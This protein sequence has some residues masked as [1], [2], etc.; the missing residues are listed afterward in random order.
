VDEEAVLT[1]AALGVAEGKVAAPLAEALKDAEPARRA[2]AA[3][4]LGRYGT[5]EQR[6]A[7]RGLLSDGSPLVRFRAAQGLLAV[8]D[9]EALLPLAA[10][11]ADSSLPLALRADELLAA[12]ALSHAPRVIPGEDAATRTACR[13][14][15]ERWAR[16]W[17]P[18]DLARGTVDLPPANPALQAAAVCRRFVLALGRG[19]LDAGRELAEVPCLTQ[20]TIAEGRPDLGKFLPLFTQVLHSQSAPLAQS[21]ARFLGDAPRVVLPVERTF[22]GRF[23]KGEVRPVE[24]LWNAP[25]RGAGPTGVVLLVRQS[26]G[27]FRIV[28]ISLRQ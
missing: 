21:A 4:V 23:R 3:L 6:T 13:A 17:G 24:L 22:L 19:D 7:V 28:G 20:A 1:L 8:R 2:A 9:R 14:A 27:A 25:E 15:W 10:L 16:R 26:A 11:T 12:T 18:T 5:P